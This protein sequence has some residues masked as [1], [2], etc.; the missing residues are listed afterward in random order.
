MTMMKILQKSPFIKANYQQELNQSAPK[1]LIFDLETTPNSGFYWGQNWETSIIKNIEYGKI[2][3][4]SAKWLGDKRV[5]T[6]GWIDNKKF[7]DREL[8]IVKELW[9]LLN[10]ADAVVAHNGKSFDVKKCNTKF[11]F[12]GLGPPSPYKI[13]DTKIEAKKYISLPSY[14]LNNIA[15]YFGLGSKVEHEG[16]S[17]W[18][19]CIAGKKAAWA[20]MKKYNKQDVVLLEE[21]Y[22]KLLPWMKTQVNAG[23]YADKVVCPRCGGNKLQSRGWTVTNVTRYKRIQCMGCGSW[24]RVPGKVPSETKPFVAI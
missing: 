4:Y 1:I 23:M 24:S 2:L 16:F 19:K 13:I 6:R 15:D 22:L 5:T 11:A 14:S 20:K 12:Y 18:E 17:L 8:P 10:E 9:E 7:N 21:I 3:S